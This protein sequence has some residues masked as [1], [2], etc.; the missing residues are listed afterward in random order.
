MHALRGQNKEPFT[1]VILRSNHD[2]ITVLYGVFSRVHMSHVDWIKR[3][4]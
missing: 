1:Y 2:T 3:A 4:L